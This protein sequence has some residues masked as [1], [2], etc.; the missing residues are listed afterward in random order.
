MHT[1]LGHSA[2]D[3]CVHFLVV[4]SAEA[5]VI[6]ALDIRASIAWSASS[7]PLSLPSS[8]S[9]PALQFQHF[10]EEETKEYWLM[11]MNRKDGEMAAV[12]HELQKLKVGQ[13]F[14][15]NFCAKI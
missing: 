6:C 1:L 13:T 4:A 3:I 7:S 9:D 15:L 11:E 12:E 2:D 10:A 8:L 14:A 5:R